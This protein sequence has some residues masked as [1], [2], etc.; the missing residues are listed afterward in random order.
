MFNFNIIDLKRTSISFKY[1][2]GNVITKGGQTGV[3]SFELE[4]VKYITF[5]S[6]K[7]GE[8][9]AFRIY[10]EDLNRKRTVYTGMILYTDEFSD[11]S[12]TTWTVP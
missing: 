9:N 2:N 10:L 12:G 5:V 1:L 7:I 6:E 8:K 4:K 11:W 3:R